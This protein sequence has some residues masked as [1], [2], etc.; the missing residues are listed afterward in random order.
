MLLKVTKGFI[1]IDSELIFDAKLQLKGV[2]NITII[3]KFDN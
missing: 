3:F 2:T 1:D